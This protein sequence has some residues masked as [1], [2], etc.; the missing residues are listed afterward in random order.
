MKIEKEK[1]FVYIPLSIGDKVVDFKHVKMPYFQ[2]ME[3]DTI[4]LERD[5][6]QYVF[7]TAKSELKVA[8]VCYS[9]V[10]KSCIVITEPKK[11]ADEAEL[12]RFK[13]SISTT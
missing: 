10:D 5:H 2:I 9:V 7:M 13:N 4:T 3:G 12:Q 11:L 8:K 1:L 6:A